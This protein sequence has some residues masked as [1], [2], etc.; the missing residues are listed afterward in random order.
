[1][2]TECVRGTLW[3][4]SVCPLQ[5]KPLSPHA[6]TQWKCGGRAEGWQRRE[7][8]QIV[9]WWR[10]L[11]RVLICWKSPVIICAQTAPPSQ[12]Y[13]LRVLLIDALCSWG[14]ICPV[15]S[16]EYVRPDVHSINDSKHRWMLPYKI[17][18][19]SFLL[20]LSVFFG[21]KLLHK[22]LY[23]EFLFPKC[24]WL[25]SIFLQYTRKSICIENW[26]CDSSSC[27][28]A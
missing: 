22:L 28:W 6:Q 12:S 13:T 7:I 20:V 21:R 23:I 15:G 27:Q 26:S 2:K 10:A 3:T 19:L 4:H 1:M 14:F 25:L 17:P 24:D 9:W 16:W 18:S 8:L 11:C 5:F